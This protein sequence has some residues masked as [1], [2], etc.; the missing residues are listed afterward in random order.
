MSDNHSL[1]TPD[2]TIDVKSPKKVPFVELHD[3]RLQGVVSSKSSYERVYVSYIEANTG[4]FYCQT[5]NNRQCGG[6]SGGVTAS[7]APCKHLDRLV[8]TAIAR[9]SSERVLE[10]LGLE[11]ETDGV[12]NAGTLVRRLEGTQREQEDS[13]V[14]SRFLDYL[15]YLDLE[16]TDEHVPEMSWFVT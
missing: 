2:H 16:G 3:G 8:D 10:Y 13:E 12:R 5:N 9:M 14:F 15:Q 7:G 11:P 6:L 4:D 1:K